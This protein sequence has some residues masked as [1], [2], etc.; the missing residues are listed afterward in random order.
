MK[1]RTGFVSNSSSASFV[2]SK[3]GLSDLQLEVVKNY[4]KIISAF[5]PEKHADICDWNIEEYDDIFVFECSDDYF[6]LAD[7][8]I[9]LGISP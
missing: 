1:I 7:E 8:F 3:R 4:E 5:L 9:K 2:I 6:D